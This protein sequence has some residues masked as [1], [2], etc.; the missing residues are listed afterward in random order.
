MP[1]IKSPT[2]QAKRKPF[3][4][5]LAQ[6]D[7]AQ[8]ATDQMNDL[9]HACTQTGKAGS[10]T[11]TVKVKAI[12]TTGQVEIDTD[13]KSKVPTEVRAKTLMF[14]TADNNLQRENPNQRS[15]EGIRDADQEAQARGAARSVE[16]TAPA[17]ELRAV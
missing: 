12:G 8:E 6:L 13:V 15:L 2:L 7:A 3:A 14:A 4:E 1:A 9:V 5:V 16:D 17:R 10:L 11:I